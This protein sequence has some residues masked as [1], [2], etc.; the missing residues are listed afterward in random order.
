TEPSLLA[1]RIALRE[2]AE[3]RVDRR[4]GHEPGVLSSPGD[5][6]GDHLAPARYG[7]RRAHEAVF[8]RRHR[9]RKIVLIRARREAVAEMDRRNIVLL[10]RIGGTECNHV[11]R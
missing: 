10:R 2:I 1:A 9:E 8:L 5:E 6:R 4:L 7:I 3:D 11:S